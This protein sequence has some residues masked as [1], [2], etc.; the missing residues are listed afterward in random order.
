MS[1]N[2][3]KTAI[4]V[5]ASDNIGDNMLISNQDLLKFQIIPINF[6]YEVLTYTVSTNI[7]ESI[8]HDFSN[9]LNDRLN[10][11]PMKTVAFFYS[12]AFLYSPRRLSEKGPENFF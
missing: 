3:I 7:L 5:V 9:V 11:I 12:V 1:S 10:P 4:R 6:P 8:K 2:G